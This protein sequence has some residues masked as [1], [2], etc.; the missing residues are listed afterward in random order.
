M[1]GPLGERKQSAD[2]ACAAGSSRWRITAHSFCVRGSCNEAASA[3]SPCFQRPTHARFSA[4]MWLRIARRAFAVE[5]PRQAYDTLKMREFRQHDRQIYVQGAVLMT[6]RLPGR[7]RATVH[8]WAL[9]I[10]AVSRHWPR[11]AA[12]DPLLPKSQVGLV[13]GD[14]ARW[15]AVL[16]SGAQSSTAASYRL[17]PNAYVRQPS[18]LL[19]S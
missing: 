8:N 14:A 9:C 17:R 13:F 10:M 19:G 1:L 18:N 12:R 5:A 6:A 11:H 4:W 16:L 2:D 7:R 15:H 3:R